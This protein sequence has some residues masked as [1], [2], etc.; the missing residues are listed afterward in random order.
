MRESQ[1]RCLKAEPVSKSRVGPSV[2][3]SKQ[4]LLN[5]S[6]SLVLNIGHWGWLLLVIMENHRK[7]KLFLSSNDMDLV[8]GTAVNWPPLFSN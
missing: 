1:R 7:K 5:S 2:C 6:V 3:I 4:C 8:G